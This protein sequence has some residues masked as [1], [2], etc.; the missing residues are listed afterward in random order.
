MDTNELKKKA[1]EKAAESIK[2][3]MVV[4]LGTGSTVYYTIMKVGELVRG[5]MKLVCI[6]TSVQTEA[7][8]KELGIPLTTLAEH[9][10]ID[11]TIDGADEVDPDFNLIKGMGGALLREKVVATASARE[12]IIVDDSKLVQTLGTRSPLPVEVIP[13]ALDVVKP[14]LAALGCDPVPRMKRSQ[15]YLTD[16]GNNVLDCRFRAI[17]DPVGLERALNLMSG[18]VENGLFLGLTDE[19]VVAS[20]DGVKTL[21]H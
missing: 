14:R 2:D 4:G 21:R 20:A 13:F 5:G 15:L 1:G 6:P 12:I 3:G 8:V 7:L 16:N 19:V 17:E 11:L 10:E 9:P 18:V